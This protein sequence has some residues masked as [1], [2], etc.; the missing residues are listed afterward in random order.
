M[1]FFEWILYLS[2]VT[3]IVFITISIIYSFKALYPD[4]QIRKP[5]LFFF[6]SIA[7]KKIEDFKKEFATLSEKEILE[8]INDQVYI[9]STIAK[10]KME[11]IRTSITNFSIGAFSLLITLLLLPW[12]K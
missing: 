12:L 9:N 4:I 5:S 1:G 2:V 10:V 6:G 8:E 3:F 11:K 7:S